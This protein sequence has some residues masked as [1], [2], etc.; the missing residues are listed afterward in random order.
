MA[1]IAPMLSVLDYDP[2]ANPPNY[3]KFFWKFS[4]IIPLKT[5]KMQSYSFI[6][7]LLEFLIFLIGNAAQEVK[8]NTL[9]LKKDQQLW[10][11]KIDQILKREEQEENAAENNKE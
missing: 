9:K 5:L 3:G 1:D 7:K 4:L 6:V 10:E 8:E 2:Y 11:K